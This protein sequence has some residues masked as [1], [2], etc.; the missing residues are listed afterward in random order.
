MKYNYQYLENEWTNGYWN[1][2]QNNLD[3]DLYWS[4]ISENPSITM[5]FINDHPDKPWNWYGISYSSNLTMEMI[6][7]HHDKPWYWCGISC[8]PSITMKDIIENPDKDKI[9]HEI[10]QKC[11]LLINHLL[12]ESNSDLSVELMHFRIAD[13]R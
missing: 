11:P 12:P 1:F 5:E 10:K 3:K 7:D 2:I 9:S 6:N 8:N 13:T 4:L